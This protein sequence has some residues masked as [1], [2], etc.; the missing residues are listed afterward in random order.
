MPRGTVASDTE[1]DHAGGSRGDETGDGDG[2]VQL[3]RSIP[4]NNV[5]TPQD[6]SRQDERGLSKSAQ[7]LSPPV[8]P[9]GTMRLTNDNRAGWKCG[10][11]RVF[12]QIYPLYLQANGSLEEAV[13]LVLEQ[14]QQEASPPTSP[15]PHSAFSVT[16]DAQFAAQMEDAFGNARKGEN[17]PGLLQ[18]NIP[19]PLAR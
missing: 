9:S 7:L 10:L 12:L 17:F 3:V 1:D 18:A 14:T 8:R 13:S 4:F 16:L 5:C 15:S 11:R 19:A 6:Q 2:G